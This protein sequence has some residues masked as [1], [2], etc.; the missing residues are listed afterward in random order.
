MC[1]RRKDLWPQDLQAAICEADE[2]ASQ[3]LKLRN[4]SKR[5]L[6][7][8]RL[9]VDNLRDQLDGHQENQIRFIAQNKI[10]LESLDAREQV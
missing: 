7:A 6:Q 1:G 5:D 4:F 9:Q 8:A 10:Q 3:L 2:Q